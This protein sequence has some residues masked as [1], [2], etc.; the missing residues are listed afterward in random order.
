MEIKDIRACKLDVNM[1]DL[2]FL[3]TLGLS[4]YDITGDLVILHMTANPNESH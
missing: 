2:Q 3:Y 4:C 1:R